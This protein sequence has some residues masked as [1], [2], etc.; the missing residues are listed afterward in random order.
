MGSID[1]L[2][3]N[4]AVLNQKPLGVLEQSRFDLYKSNPYHDSTWPIE[5][6]LEHDS[7][8]QSHPHKTPFEDV[9]GIFEIYYA[10]KK[11]GKP[12]SAERIGKIIGI[13]CGT[14]YR[15]LKKVGTNP[16]FRTLSRPSYE[17]K[18][19]VLRLWETP[20][21]APDIAY[22]ANEY[23][24]TRFHRATFNNIL[25]EKGSVRNVDNRGMHAGRVPLNYRLASQIYEARDAGFKA[26]NIPERTGATEAQIGLAMELEKGFK[27]KII[28]ALRLLT[29]TDISTPY[30]GSLRYQAA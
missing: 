28:N 15:I 18:E 6:A 27:P 19:A 24:E 5:K 12:I 2:V 4:G 21:P 10:A 22:F 3:Q 29:E 7:I 14:V 16:M 1:E 17:Q 8:T 9:L 25:K 30:L 13:D 20:L 11:L 26:E 23:F